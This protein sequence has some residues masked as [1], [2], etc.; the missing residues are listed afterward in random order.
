MLS[1]TE[2]LHIEARAYMAQARARIDHALDSVTGNLHTQLSRLD[3]AHAL[4]SEAEARIKR[5]Q[6][7]PVEAE[8]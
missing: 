6:A 2:K 5:I 4:L 1:E 7:L 8:D 3:Q